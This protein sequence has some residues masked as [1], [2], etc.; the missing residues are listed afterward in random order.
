M[1]E[2]KKGTTS[3]TRYVMALKSSDGTPLTGATITNFDLQYTRA[4][5]A[6]AA[7]VDAT[8]TPG[9]AGGAWDDNTMV[10]VDA[11]SSPGLYR[12]DWP[13]AAFA[14]GVDHVILMVTNS[15]DSM[16]PAAE[17]I[18]LVDNVVGDALDANDRVD[19]GSWLGTAVTTSSTS[20]KPEVDAFSVSDDA[21]AANNLETAC[22]NYSATRGLSGTALPAAAA[23]AAGGLPISDAGGLD[24]DALN[25]AAVRLT[26]ARAQVLDDWINAGRL[27]AILDIIAADVVNLDGAAMRGTDSAALASVCTEGR[28]AE[29]DAAN[30]PAVI[31]AIL[32]DTAEIGAAGAGLT[33]LGG[34]SSGMKAEVESE[35]N[36]ALVAQKLDHLVAVADADDA[37]DDSILAKLAASTGDWSDF[38]SSTDALQAIRDRGDAAWSSIRLV[39]TTMQAGSTASLLVALAADLPG[40]GSNDADD[41][42]NGAMVIARDVNSGSRINIRLVSDYDAATDTFTLDSALGFTPEAGV[43][44]FEVWA[45]PGAAILVEIL[46]LSTGF[47]A[48]SPDNLIGHLRAMMSKAAT[49]PSGVGTYLP[50]TDSLEILGES[51][52]AMK[53]AGFA[54]GTDSLEAIRNAIDDLVSPLV[55]TATGTLSGV[56]FLSECVS[57]IRKATDE[58]DTGPKYPDAD[59]IE[60]IHSAFDQVL[61]SIN[62]ETDHPILTR[63][64]V[65]IVSGTQ[66]YLLPCNIAEIWRIAKID[67]N[68]GVPLWEVW[69]TNEYTFRGDGWTVEGNILRFHNLNLNA[70]TLEILY[71][72]SG[73]VSIHT[74][75][76]AAGAVNSITFAASPTD[77]ALDIRPHAYAGYMVRT[78]SGTGAGQERIVSAYDAS[79]R[80]ATPRPNWTTAPDAATVYEVLPHYYTA[81]RLIKHAVALYATLDVLGN[82][83][84]STRRKEIE[85]QLQRK[86]SALKMVLA[87]KVRRFGTQGPGVDTYDNDDVW[88]LLP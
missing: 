86:M 85:L 38:V 41:D 21:A 48:A 62:V 4:G 5:A 81:N 82:E 63:R 43:D 52:A 24:L 14:T 1:A 54:T 28:L 58:P 73:D 3:V 47:G 29:L 87:K 69:P 27:D 20:A 49:A 40:A 88:P 6:A 26:A 64:D 65:S 25:T 22:D 71:I 72:A 44:T 8:A 78:L 74:A 70:E 61:A 35:C 23:D 13:D 30:L 79:T 11:T 34:M 45:D 57:L 10:E 16:V 36:D 75:T 7:K 19:V 17:E 55:I 67:T 18:T 77:G 12:V 84:K 76:A 56:G 39:N 68:S 33:D 15:T 50:S 37:V 59:L 32:T 9:G 66:D 53:G 46:K 31:D 80:I 42:Y 51:A 2:I 60:Y 83:A